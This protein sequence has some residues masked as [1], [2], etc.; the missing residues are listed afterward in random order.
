[1]PL[2][3][4]T[5]STARAIVIASMIAIGCR[6]DSRAASSTGASGA[7]AQGSAVATVNGVPILASELRL[8]MAAAAGAKNPHRPD[9]AA[10]APPVRADVVERLIDD[11]LA[12]QYARG[13]RIDADP[14]LQ[15]ELAAKQAELD[16][17]TRQ[18]LAALAIREVRAK[19]TTS[20]AEIRRFFDENTERVRTVTQV[21]QILLHDRAAI[22]QAR[23]D[24]EGGAKFE[25]VAARQFSSSLPAGVRPWEVGEL[26]WNQ[27]PP[28]W[29]PVL[30]G[31]A[32]GAISPIIEGPRGRV[33]IIKVIA[34]RVDPTITFESARPAI[35]AMLQGKA[36][37]AA[38]AAFAR[39]LRANA[40]I[41]KS[42][43]GPSDGR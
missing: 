11:E 39:T 8:A 40:T 41:S 2:I 31:L 33:W 3:E 25:D 38:Q 23:R 35:A 10:A 17:F 43:V 27:I 36:A 5:S 7:R 29:E 14:E 21:W 32:I 26:T 15:R 34:R 16:Q 19:A 30:P 1:M 42:P 20:D 22:E 13:K 4:R 18:R 6:G 24:L 37:D 12:A 9:E 28:Q